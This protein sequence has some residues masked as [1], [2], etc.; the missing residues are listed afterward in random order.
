MLRLLSFVFAEFNR[1]GKEICVCGEMAG[2]PKAAVLLAGLGARR[3]SMSAANDAGVKAALAGISLKTAED[4]AQ[5]CMQMRTEK[6]I[7]EYLETALR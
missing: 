2:N 5:R 3:L 7:I 6:E 1:R 4:I